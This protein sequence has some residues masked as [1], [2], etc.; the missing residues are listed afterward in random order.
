MALLE[1]VNDPLELVVSVLYRI[2]FSQAFGEGN[3]R[4]ALLLALWVADKNGL[5][6]KRLMFEDDEELGALLVK[7]ASGQDV[8]SQIRNVISQRASG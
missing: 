4:T 5:D 3:K 7:A 2:A 6:T 8:E 1:R